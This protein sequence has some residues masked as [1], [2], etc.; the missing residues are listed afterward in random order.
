[1]EAIILSDGESVEKL[2]THISLLNTSNI[3]KSLS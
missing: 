3:L 1:M 2:L